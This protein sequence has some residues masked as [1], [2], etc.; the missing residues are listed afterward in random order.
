VAASAPHGARAASGAT[1]GPAAPDAAAPAVPDPGAPAAP[2]PTTPLAGLRLADLD[3][4]P[5]GLDSY[6]GRGPVLLDFWAMWCKPC[7]AALPELDALHADLSPR[8]LQI[9]GINQD[10]ARNIEKIKPFLAAQGIDFPIL[11]DTDHT[12]RRRL[13]AIALPTTLLFDSAGKLVHAQYGYRPGEID[14]LRAKIAPLLAA[15]TPAS[16]Q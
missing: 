10:T 6:L 9:V 12:A 11:L 14:H 4:K 16:S 2:V 15:P 3:G 1:T 13:N 5:V 8:G 7:L